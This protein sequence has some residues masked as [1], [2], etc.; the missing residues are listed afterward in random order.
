MV[1]QQLI[2]WWEVGSCHARAWPEKALW[3]LSVCR[4][5][6]R[7][8]SGMK[9]QQ[10]VCKELEGNVRNAVFRESCEG[11]ALAFPTA[12]LGGITSQPHLCLAAGRR[13][14]VGAAN[15]IGI[16]TCLLTAGRTLSPPEERAEGRKNKGHSG[17]FETMGLAGWQP[18]G[19]FSAQHHSRGGRTLPQG[20]AKRLCG[21][22]RSVLRGCV[23]TPAPRR[24]QV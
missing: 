12:A 14:S 8:R 3:S 15:G 19:S 16:H 21:L 13:L 22:S 20:L 6:V 24:S 1:S 23:K 5:S 9:E 2:V 4:A 10:C 17:S 7:E 11:W 18:A